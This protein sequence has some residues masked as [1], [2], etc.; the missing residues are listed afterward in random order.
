[1]AK[2]AAEQAGDEDGAWN[3]YHNAFEARVGWR[4]TVVA[5]AAME[6]AQPPPQRL[7]AGVSQGPP[8]GR[9][10]RHAKFGDGTVIRENGDVLDIAFDA[11]GER[12]VLCRFVHM[13]P[14]APEPPTGT[15]AAPPNPII[16][17]E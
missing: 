9:R 5:A 10:V 11:C 14:S 12:R 1:M 17:Q 4:T 16:E 7:Y 13:L 3:A 15:V 8:S 2:R 6:A